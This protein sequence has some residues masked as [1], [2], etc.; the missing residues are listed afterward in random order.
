MAKSSPASPVGGI[1]GALRSTV[2][3]V[4]AAAAISSEFRVRELSLEALQALGVGRAVATNGGMWTALEVS[5]VVT[6]QG[7]RWTIVRGTRTVTGTGARSR[8]PFVALSVG[9][10]GRSAPSHEGGGWQGAEDVKTEEAVLGLVPAIN[11]TKV[12]GPGDAE[13]IGSSGG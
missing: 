5:R 1:R 6:T 12:V 13:V 2:H 8:G 7:R 11:V 9:E 4:A 10:W 3:A